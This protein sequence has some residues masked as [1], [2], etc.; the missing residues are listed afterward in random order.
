MTD[1][2]SHRRTYAIGGGTTGSGAREA[3]VLVVGLL[4]IYMY[5]EFG[6]ADTF[7]ASFASWTSHLPHATLHP[8]FYSAAS[9]VFWRLLVPLFA[10]V[11]ILRER[12]S[13]FG[14]RWNPIAGFGRIYAVMFAV[15]LPIVWWCAGQP[16]FQ[17]KYPFWKDAGQSV[18][19]LLIYE[20]RYLMVFV[21][22]EAFWRGFLLFGLARRF[23]W[24]A[25]SISMV[26]YVMVH[27]GKPPIET[28]GAIVTGYVLGYLALTHRSFWLGVVI[29]FG[30][31]LSMDLAVLARTGGLPTSW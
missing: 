14:Y 24:H 9:S 16:S 13:E 7:R 27:F 10:V 17:A 2:D 22:G 20:L 23:G 21:S 18:R 12:P 5:M 25:L 26:P 4:A 3:V 11:V 6:R 28:L 8:F 19:M 15:M 31:G 1:P 29:H 30:V